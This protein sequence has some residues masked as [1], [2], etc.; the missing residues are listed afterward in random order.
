MTKK[1]I[2]FVMII[3][4]SANAYAWDASS[5][6]DAWGAPATVSTCGSQDLVAASIGADRA[7][8]V[9]GAE[10]DYPEGDMCNLWYSPC[11]V[12]ES[13]YVHGYSM[14]IARELN[15]NGAYFCPTVVGSNK[16]GG[17]ELSKTGDDK[18]YVTIYRE[19]AAVNAQSC[20]WVCKSGFH[21]DGCQE[22]TANLCD[23][24]SISRADWD[25][26]K[27]EIVK[28]SQNVEDEVA[29]FANATDE[30][31][32]TCRSTG[33]SPRE[34]DI[35]LAVSDWLTDGHGVKV[36]PFVIM[37]SYDPG[38]VR[39][40]NKKYSNRSDACRSGNYRGWN[41]GPG[42]VT[43]YAVGTPTIL[44]KTGY[45]PNFQNDDC[46][47]VDETVCNVTA[48][49]EGGTTCDSKNEQYASF[50]AF[51]SSTMEMHYFDADSCYG[52]LC[53]QAG[54]GFNPQTGV[55]EC[56]DC[57]LTDIRNG[58]DNYGRCVR[59]NTGQIFNSATGKCVSAVA[60]DWNRLKYGP[61]KSEQTPINQQCWTQPDQY[62]Y[63][64]C[65]W[66]NSESTGKLIR[67]VG[68][69]IRLLSLPNGG[70]G[71]GSGGNGGGSGD[72]GGD[73]DNDSGGTGG[74]SNGLVVGDVMVPGPSG[75]NN[76]QT[77]SD[78]KPQI[79]TTF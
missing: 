73:N 37:A 28:A 75:G 8:G 72:A 48:A 68:T 5:Y 63:S 16:K 40:R 77:Q 66:G 59:C 78:L 53:S 74:G 19:T 9:Y 35:V 50:D 12:N 62:S 67:A 71:G 39:I 26:E 13:K 49:I 61:N 30:C 10:N 34:H 22:T 6:A 7:C 47:P 3:L 46:I 29:M 32:A 4:C 21:G 27:Y 60:L 56:I 76:L 65:V 54:Y 2:I 51:D 79:T 1:L 20:F 25:D 58:I 45:R 24:K 69:S 70:N 11:R 23:T 64:D 33:C 31:G 42:R 18:P 41:Y 38:K 57:G 44:C 17:W 14:L 15:E 55:A 43:V 52:V 36:Q